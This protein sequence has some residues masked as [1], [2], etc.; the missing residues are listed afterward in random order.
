LKATGF[1]GSRLGGALRALVW[2]F[3][4]RLYCWARGDFLNRP[5]TNGEYWL[6]E[7]F[8]ESAG[9][10]TVVLDVGANVGDWTARVLEA[11]AARGAQVE[12][13]A[14]EPCS[15][16]RALLAQR[17]SGR[18]GVAI[19]PCAVSASEG[20]AD[21]FS[22]GAG[23]GTNSLAARPGDAVERVRTTTIDAYAAQK[24]LGA[25]GLLKIDAEGY[26]FA[27]LRG[28]ERLLAS[29][30]V[31]VVQFEYNWQWLS[32]HVSLRDVFDFIAG[33]PYRLGKL[34]G[35][36]VE[37][38]AEWHFELDRF[39]ENNYVLVRE[40][41]PLLDGARAMSFDASNCAREVE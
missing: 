31:E 11:A 28:A 34:A 25:I 37:L 9:P 6:I 40:G 12:V 36:A 13:H 1:R 7:N 17:L 15:A 14:F 33:K 18:R 20:E 16:T 26:D 30:R 2:R 29:G 22:R 4:R 23:A 41:S 27:V 5:E 8:F 32:N 24:G 38:Y 35:P 3:G 39:F 21:F 19:S 10:D